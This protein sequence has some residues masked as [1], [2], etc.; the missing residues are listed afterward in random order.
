[1]NIYRKIADL[2]RYYRN[3]IYKRVSCIRGTTF[4]R[5]FIF[6]LADRGLESYDGSP[7]NFL[8]NDEW[9]IVFILDACRADFFKELT[10]FSGSRVSL[11]G[12]SKEFVSQAFSDSVYGDVVYI[13]GNPHFEQSIFRDITSKGLN[14]VFYEVF[15]VF[16]TGWDGEEGTVMPEE[17]LRSLDTARKLFPDKRIVVHFMQP[18]A[19][20]VN[21][22]FETRSLVSLTGAEENYDRSSVDPDD[23]MS[24]AARGQ[25]SD[26]VLRE[27]YMKNLEFVWNEIIDYVSNT[28]LDRKVYITADHGENLGEGG[29]YGHTQGGKN[30]YLREVPWV[31]IDNKFN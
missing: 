15:D 8:E 9:D 31:R 6:Q 17:L 11:G 10:G 18:H 21:S 12:A 28:D 29:L 19:P 13:S 26:E 20:F 3:N 25:I 1:M 16:N 5:D 7:D 22:D 27:E 2:N 14:D 24:L 23:V 30:N 4:L